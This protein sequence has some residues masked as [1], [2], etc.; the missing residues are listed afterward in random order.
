MGQTIGKAQIQQGALPFVNLPRSLVIDLRQ[1]VHEVAE[2]YG[3]VLSELQEVIRIS[4]REFLRISECNI[5]EC[6]EVLFNLFK[7][8]A[9]AD[10]SESLIDS[11]EFLAAL[12]LVSG[13]QPGEK[14][15]FIFDLFD[16]NESGQLDVNEVTLAFRASA[17]GTTKL[18]AA[19]IPVKIEYI[20]Q[21][22]IEAF[23]ISAP[24]SLKCNPAI[25]AENHKLNRQDFFNYVV[26][27]PET[28]S[29]LNHFDDINDEVKPNATAHSGKVS[30]RP[31][32]LRFSVPFND[33]KLTSGSDVPW[34]DQ[35][36]FLTP[37]RASE[38]ESPPRVGLSLDWIYGRN[39][40]GPQ[41]IYGENGE[42]FYPAGSMIVKLYTTD[43]GKMAQDYFSEHA[44]HVTSIDIFHLNHSRGEIIASADLGDVSKVC[45]WSTATL[46]SIVT[47]PRFHQVSIS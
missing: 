38:I 23:E 13:M 34:R 27:C 12:C 15:N 22:A 44:G 6:S 5:D 9:S 18:S 20:D 16:F 30:I 26:N 11:F 42:I 45:V 14:I 35:I 47:I 37:N 7:V 28:A 3:L 25:L 2:G 10:C 36:R 21:V 31:T 41:A 40:G 24:A 39:T 1:A 32:P 29:I 46:C 43:D 4:L 17:S 19:S 33:Q 8:D